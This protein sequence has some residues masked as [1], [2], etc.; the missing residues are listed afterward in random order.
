[1]KMEEEIILDGL[2]MTGTMFKSP[3]R[4]LSFEDNEYIVTDFK[5]NLKPQTKGINENYLLDTNQNNCN[6]DIPTISCH[7]VK[8]KH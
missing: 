7:T 6:P 8:K 5:P 2:K 1:M 4:S 3:M